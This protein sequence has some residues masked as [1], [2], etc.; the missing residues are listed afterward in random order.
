MIGAPVERQ[1]S[2]DRPHPITQ[3]DANFVTVAMPARPQV[4]DSDE[5]SQQQ[6]GWAKP[7]SQRTTDGHA[8]RGS[9]DDHQNA[10][11]D[12]RRQGRRDHGQRG[13]IR[14]WIPAIGHRLDLQRS[15]AGNVGD[16]RSGNASKHET[17]K[18]IDMPQ[19]AAQPLDNHLGS[20][21]DALGQAAALHDL[22]G[23]DE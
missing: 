3:T 17:G 15:E 6:Q 16:G 8:R 10:G 19:A 2:Y 14:A 13:A 22:A 7:T 5:A 21:E 11:R 20:G 1:R 4:V 12:D 18:N 9:R 23:E